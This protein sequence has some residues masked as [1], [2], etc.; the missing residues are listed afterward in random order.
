MKKD[1]GCSRFKVQCSSGEK[2]AF[3]IRTR[4]GLQVAGCRMQ[5]GEKC[6]FQIYLS[7]VNSVPLCETRNKIGS[8]IR[9]GEKQA[10]QITGCI[11]CAFVALCE[12]GNRIRIEIGERS[13][14]FIFSSVSSVPLCETRNKIGSGI[15]IGE[16]YAFQIYIPSELCLCG[17]V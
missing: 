14:H 15:R 17:F 2:Y 16:K 12:T 4:C 1:A 5:V 8:G 9:I 13:T 11:F 7:A 10:F 6:A 3:Q